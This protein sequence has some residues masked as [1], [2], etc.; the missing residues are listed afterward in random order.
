[1]GEMKE[2][3]AVS[4]AEQL[5]VVRE[6]QLAEKVVFLDGLAGCG[7]TMLAP[8]VSAMDR[9]ELLTYAY[10]V[11]YICA[12]YHL[13]KIS[14]DAAETA[15][16]LFTDLKLYNTMMSRE[17]NFRYTD[18]SSAFKYV[19]PLKYLK[20]LF[21]KGDENVPARVRSE[22]PI[23]NFVVHDLLP[24]SEPIFSAL[25]PK[26]CFVDVVRHPLYMFRQ[27]SLN[28]Q[29]LVGS[30]RDFT[31]YFSSNQGPAPYYAYGW[32][33]QFH[34]SNPTDKSIYYIA[35]LL[36]MTA[37][38]KKRLKEKYNANILTVPFEKFVIDPGPFMNEIEAFI[39]SRVTAQTR[40]MMRK[41][42]VPRAKYA[43]GISID[44]Y[45]RCGWEPPRRGA[46]ENDEFEVRRRLAEQEASAAGMAVLNKI[47]DEYEEEFL[48]GRLKVGDSYA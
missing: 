2:K 48:G 19:K 1:M 46:S 20:R 41:Q 43:E 47:C 13:G 18:L 39:G 44:I 8:I 3:L 42:H 7:K 38:S 24:F 33:D 36:T 31:V 17:T 26:A 29:D 11:E 34:A 21:Q 32:E 27:I 6:R 25:G 14:Q 22:R 5:T 12:L 23:L 4:F 30:E 37:Q 40:R 15:V 10:E 16:S 28:M 45:K 35:N 9:V